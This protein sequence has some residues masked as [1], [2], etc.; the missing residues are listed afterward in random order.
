MLRKFEVAEKYNNELS[1]YLTY[2][3]NTIN[4]MYS[5]MKAI[6]RRGSFEADD[7]VGYFFKSLKEMVEELKKITVDSTNKESV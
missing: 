1:G 4:E 2:M 6:D 7:E 5:V 3:E